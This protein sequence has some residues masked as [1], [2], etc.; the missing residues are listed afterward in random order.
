MNQLKRFLY[1]ITI[2]LSFQNG[3]AQNTEAQTQID[4]LYALVHKATSNKSKAASML[5]LCKYYEESASSNLDSLQKYSLKIYRLSKSDK[6]LQE[7][8]ILALSHL[9]HRAIMLKQKDSARYFINT[10]KN[11]SET[12]DYG[13]GL[14]Y[15]HYRESFYSQHIDY[16]TNL[17]IYHFQNAYK[18]AKKYQLPEHIVFGLGA[19]LSYLYQL[20]DYN[21]DVTST[22]LFEIMA[23]ADAPGVTKG[24]K[25]MFYR[26]I[27]D[28]YQKNK[29]FDKAIFNFEKAVE[30]FK[31][32]NSY[33]LG[34]AMLDLAEIHHKLNDNKK[35]IAIF[36]DILDLK[37]SNKRINPYYG[38]AYC[39]FDLKEYAISKNYY[40]KALEVYK[41]RNI[42]DF[43]AACLK[44][45]G[46]ISLKQNRT[47]EANTYFN[48]A[49]NKYNK[50]IADKKKESRYRSSLIKIYKDLSSIYEYQNKLTKSLT[51]YKLYAAH[52]DT[53]NKKQTLRVTERF[54]FFAKTTE[55]NKEIKELK[56]LTKF[57]ELNTKKDRQVKI[58]LFFSLAFIGILLAVIYNR[59]H[60]KRKA[61]KIIEE[62]NEENKLLM[63]EIHHRVKNNLQIISSLLGVQ[64]NN[65]DNDRLK[66]ILQESQNKIKSMSLI[67]QNLYKGDQFAKV[68]VGSYVNELVA[69]IESSYL[70]DNSKFSFNLD[71]PEEQI[72]IGLA[73][74]LG[75]ILNELITNSFKYAFLDNDTKEKIISIQFKK[76]KN[77]TT[78]SLIVKDNGKGIPE[79]F[80]LENLSTFG[81]QLVYGLTE[82]LHGEVNIVQDEGTTFN[83]VLEAPID[84]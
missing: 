31:D 53:I 25:G 67:H 54:E 10:F 60:S 74:P 65:S 63:R 59:Y 18:T 15:A 68:S 48:L 43:E 20:I 11:L 40:E 61:L 78:Y 81:L 82:Q 9:A 7:S 8:S 39:Y 52:K 77:K 42:L 75:L 84:A 28:V 41:A 73:V 6:A 55:K 21:T 2:L 29:V 22:I 45:L 58:G 24:M 17:S 35:A 30:L 83:I 71:I 47:K 38:L 36:E 79:N 26:S 44:G 33:Q 37:F 51:Y 62:K 66:L 72:P 1:V 14:T 12:L 4:S 57:Q 16:D 69:E 27:A 76:L 23:Y 5:Q 19:E 3:I 13:T 64:I 46:L 70:E 49:I 34:F 50:I 56:I 32:I 80:D